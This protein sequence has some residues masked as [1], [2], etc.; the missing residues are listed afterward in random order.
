ML[1]FSMLLAVLAAPALPSHSGTPIGEW[2]IAAC[3]VLVADQ[4]AKTFVLAR[5]SPRQSFRGSIGTWIRPVRQAGT[6]LGLIR[7]RAALVL[8]WCAAAAATGVLILCA[9]PFRQHWA[10]IGLGAGLGGAAGN[11][12]DMLRLGKVVDFIDLKIWP[13]FNIAD[14]AIVLGV[15]AALASAAWR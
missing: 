11:L 1:F 9:E 12:F 7:N 15:S 13:V 6:G 3:A 2:V 14:V 8:L 5:A 4:A 10:V